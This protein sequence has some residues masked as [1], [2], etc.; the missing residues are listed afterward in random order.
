MNDEQKRRDSKLHKKLQVSKYKKYSQLLAA[1]DVKHSKL[2][3]A[4]DDK[5]S[6]LLAN[7][8]VKHDKLVSDLHNLKRDYN[9]VLD[10]IRIKHR[11]SLC[12]QQMLHVQH[13]EKKNK[14]VKKMWQDMQ[15]THE[16]LWEIFNEMNESKHKVKLVYTS[17]KKA[18]ATAKRATSRSSMLFIKLKESTNLINK[19]KDEV[20]DEKKVIL[21][22]RSKVD[23]YEVIIDCM[24]QEYEEKCNEH[25]TKISPIKAYYEEII[26]KQSPRYVM[27]HWVKNKESHGKYIATPILSIRSLDKRQT[28]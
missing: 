19:L 7:K 26:R 13:I 22:L 9:A 14:I 25:C 2:Q 6:R 16:M 24:E 11:S 4:M 5:Y 10:D 23:E 17:A 3:V 27:K 20:N 8:D 18:A 15:S 1:K 28:N 12:K 21:D